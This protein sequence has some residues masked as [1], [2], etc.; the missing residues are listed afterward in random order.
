MPY[1]PGSAY[2]KRTTYIPP[3]HPNGMGIKQAVNVDR[4][5][6]SPTRPSVAQMRSTMGVMDARAAAAGQIFHSA[7]PLAQAALSRRG[8][9][10][11]LTAKA[12]EVQGLRQNRAAGQQQQETSTFS[13]V[14]DRPAALPPKGVLGSTPSVASPVASANKKG[15][16]ASMDQVVNSVLTSP[17]IGVGK[18]TL[19]VPKWETK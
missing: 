17:T 7:T 15:A 10:D 18:P 5:I 14:G 6:L 2:P 11:H 8:A 19:T 16:E 13:S 1:N 4:E 9:V 12:H 3:S